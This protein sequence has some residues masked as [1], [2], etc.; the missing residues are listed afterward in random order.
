MESDSVVAMNAAF[1]VRR[2]I[3]LV[4]VLMFTI[5]AAFL[6]GGEFFVAMSTNLGNDIF[7]KELIAAMAFSFTV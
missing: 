7:A 1:Q 4:T 2:L 6:L 3:A 5:A